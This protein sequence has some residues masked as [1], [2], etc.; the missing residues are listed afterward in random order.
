[1]TAESRHLDQTIADWLA[2]GPDVATGETRIYIA[3]TIR[4]TRQ[5]GTLRTIGMTRQVRLL[6]AASLVVAAVA[7]AVSAGSTWIMPRETP[8][9]TVRQASPSSGPSRSPV[10][11]AWPSI[12]PALTTLTLDR[13]DRRVTV[14]YDA[15]AFAEL[16]RSPALPGIAAFSSVPDAPSAPNGSGPDAYGITIGDMTDARGHGIS[17]AVPGELG[18]DPDEFMAIL[19]ASSCFDVEDVRPASVGGLASTSGR[20]SPGPGCW[21]HIDAFVARTVISFEFEKPNV[22]WAIRVG[23]AFILVQAWAD[24]PEMLDEW[25]PDAEALIASMRFEEPF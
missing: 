7:L 3:A 17:G 19:D 25:L 12:D 11:T 16:E 21:T 20:V 15:T 6:L 9:P 5:R 8:L 14:G 23:T 18:L 13:G 22:T 2:N 4:R 1:M 24:T 10:P